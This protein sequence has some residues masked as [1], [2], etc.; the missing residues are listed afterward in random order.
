M[1]G[2]RSDSQ[3]Y[4]GAGGPP[5]AGR[6]EYRLMRESVVRQFR[7]GRLGRPDVCDAQPELLRVARNLGRETACLCPIC[8]DSKLVHVSFAFGPRLP[9][10]G[11]ALGAGELGKMSRSKAEVSCYV[12]EV[13]TECAWNHLLSM[14]TVGGTSG[15]RAR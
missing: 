7:R 8:E 15:N 1:P 3:S 2:V 14:F 10:C 9:S 11:R 6:I 13:C 5:R 4:W 12:V